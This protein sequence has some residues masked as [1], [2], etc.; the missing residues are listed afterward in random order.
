MKV[1]DSYGYEMAIKRPNTHKA[2]NSSWRMTTI[3][4]CCYCY[5]CGIVGGG[6]DGDGDDDTDNIS[7]FN[8]LWGLRESFI[9]NKMD[10][11]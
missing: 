8:P 1:H 10:S 9:Y 3:D 5:C 11:F 4:K 6:H 2:L 7:N